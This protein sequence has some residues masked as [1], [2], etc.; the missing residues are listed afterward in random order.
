MFCYTYVFDIKLKSFELFRLENLL[1]ECHF[2]LGSD[3][4]SNPILNV[5]LSCTNR[6][7]CKVL[8]LY[9]NQL[10][11]KIVLYNTHTY[12]QTLD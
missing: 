8:N 3:N 9:L 7:V 5:D 12:R 10:R 2:E 11:K 4:Y 6:Y 1:R